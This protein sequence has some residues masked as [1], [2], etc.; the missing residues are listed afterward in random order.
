VVF[1]ISPPGLSHKIEEDNTAKSKKAITIM[2][3]HNHT[4]L[5]FHKW[6]QADI[7]LG[8]IPF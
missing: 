1:T 5:A 2:K 7:V 3:M 6:A 8:T 4:F